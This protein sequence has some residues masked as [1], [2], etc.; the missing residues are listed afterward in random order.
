MK[1]HDKIVPEFKMKKVYF[2]EYIHQKA[3]FGNLDP[4][5]SILTQLQ[6]IFFI[7]SEGKKKKI[8]FLSLEF[9]F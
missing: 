2:K 5:Y 3:V 6:V 9:I 7:I 4:L 8:N 1:K